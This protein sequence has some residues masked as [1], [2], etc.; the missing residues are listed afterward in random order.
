MFIRIGDNAAL[1]TRYQK[2]RIH[3]IPNSLLP[4]S[5]LDETVTKGKNGRKLRIRLYD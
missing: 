4:Y 3:K 2:D 5:K 1:F